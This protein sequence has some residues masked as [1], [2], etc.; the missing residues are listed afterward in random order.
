MPE[1]KPPPVN[2]TA[3]FQAEAGGS[4]T[5]FVESPTEYLKRK[6]H[7]A[8]KRRLSRLGRAA[9]PEDLQPTGSESP[10]PPP[11]DSPPRQSDETSHLEIEPALAYVTLTMEDGSEVAWPLGRQQARQLL[12]LLRHALK[13]KAKD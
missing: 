12:R 2:L 8:R 9:V 10:S 6:S 5:L 7:E 3:A 4:A 13:E 11:P 1:K